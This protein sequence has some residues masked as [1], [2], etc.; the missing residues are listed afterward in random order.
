MHFHRKLRELFHSGDLWLRFFVGRNMSVRS[1]H[2]IINK[3]K[4]YNYISP[5]TVLL[6]IFQSHPAGQIGVFADC[7]TPQ[8]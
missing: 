7:L 4:Y 3:Q 5:I 8:H 6:Q 2:I 1:P